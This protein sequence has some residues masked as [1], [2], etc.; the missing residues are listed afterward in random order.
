MPPRAQLMRYAPFFILAKVAALNRFLVSAVSGTCSVMKSDLVMTS[1]SEASFT[2]AGSPV[3]D[4]TIG[5]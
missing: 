1:S 5:S 2:P 3:S 4:F